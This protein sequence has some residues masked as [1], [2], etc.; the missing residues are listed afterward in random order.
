MAFPYSLHQPIES[1]RSIGPKRAVVLQENGIRTIEDLL[2]YFPRRYLDRS[3]VTPIARLR[4]GEEV[5]VAGRIIQKDFVK[6]RKNRFVLVLKDDTSLLTCVW[7][8]RLSYWQKIFTIGEWLAVSGKVKRFNGY[9]M[10]HPDFDRLGGDR[11]GNINTGKIIPVYPSTESLTKV[12]LD[13][14]GLRRLINAVITGSF[15]ENIKDPLPAAMIERQD[16]MPLAAALG[17]IHFPDNF[18][19]LSRSRDRLVFSELF[20]LELMLAARKKSM[21]RS[22]IGI[23]FKAKQDKTRELLDMLPFKLT[24]AQE[25]VVAEITADMENEYSMNRLLQGDVG[26]GKTIV[27]LL[28]M[29]IAV[30]NGYQAALMAPTEI[31]AEQHFL[32]IHSL[33]ERI[34]VHVVLIVGGQ[35]AATRRQIL[36]NIES[37]FA[38]IV[39]GTH[40]V[41]QDQVEFRN[42]GFVVIDEQHR[43]GVMQRARLR[44]KGFSPDVLVMTATPIPRTLSMTVY[45]DLDVSV[46]DKLPGGRKPVR[47]TWRLENKRPQIYRFVRDQLAAGAQVYVVFPLVEES[48]KLDLKAAVDSYEIMKTR[49]FQNFRIGLLHGRMSSDEK[50]HTMNRFKAEDIDLLVST[51][52]IEVGVDVPNA[53]IMVI[54]HAERFGLTQ[55]HQLRGR[56][57]RGV[58]QSFCILIAYDPLSDEA[59]TRLN[60]MAETTDGFVI[61]ERDLKL[62]GPGDYFGVR[63]HGL[64][65]LL[66]A[67]ILNDQDILVRA[68]KEAFEFM[69]NEPK[70]DEWIENPGGDYLMRR[71]KE[72]SDFALV[73]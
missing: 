28:S 31:L 32:T 56:V 62:R 17:Q 60:A 67:D 7:F 26:S 42:L 35:P 53:T 46:L 14:R 2:Y 52:V 72:R 70:A 57:G 47:T 48:E 9:Q 50:E 11:E 63:Q 19:T 36:E 39:V 65:N 37:G 21:T 22:E 66:I 15:L 69:Q 8:S 20:Y 33:L 73:S 18:D 44:Q 58:K 4:E 68:R 64:P 27:A 71:F 34:D 6:G 23:A 13:S 12:N 25:R 38:Q 51:T 54:E 5:T 55:L 3:T 16:L 41:I 43:F 30:E 59:L 29:L 45:G 61:A 10:T 40:A 24:D 49:F 1:L